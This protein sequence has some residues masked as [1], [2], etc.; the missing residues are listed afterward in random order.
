MGSRSTNFGPGPADDPHAPTLIRQEA[1]SAARGEAMTIALSPTEPH[2]RLR[3]QDGEDR[4]RYWRARQGR[5]RL[6]PRLRRPARGRL[7]LR[8]AAF[9]CGHV[10]T[11]HPAGR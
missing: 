5:R 7:Q 2:G 3:Q 11:R 1:T 10:A 4:S 9:Q 6:R 8:M